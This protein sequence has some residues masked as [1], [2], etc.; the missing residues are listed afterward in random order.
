MIDAVAASRHPPLAVAA[1]GTISKVLEEYLSEAVHAA[2]QR[3]SS[4]QLR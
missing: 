1:C 2:H 3:Q 4:Y